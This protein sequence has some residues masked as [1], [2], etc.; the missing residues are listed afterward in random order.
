MATTS[1]SASSGTSQPR[2][3]GAANASRSTRQ[4]EPAKPLVKLVHANCVTINFTISPD[5]LKSSIPH[6][7]TLD[8]YKGDTFVSLV[9]MQIKSL[10]FCGLPI[11]PRFCELSLRC[12]V[13]ETD[14]PT[15]KGV[16]YLKSYL[17]GKF[18]AW[19]LGNLVPHNYQ[20]LAIKANHQGG[21][22]EA[23]EIDYAWKVEG[24]ENRLRVR[25]RDRIAKKET[26]TKVGFVVSH[27]S[28][29]QASQGSTIG[30]DITR[31]E[32]VLWDAAQAN[33]TCDVRRL[34]GAP[35]VKPLAARPVS[36][37]VSAGSEVTLHRPRKI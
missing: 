24:H 27:S 18:G 25:A 35:F 30:Y 37:F 16:L 6:G 14:D 15:R 2:P 34:F 5:V 28:H 20:G 33:F 8:Y 21:D 3:A 17:S 36:V 1:N 7:L 32:W 12:F 31:P 29:Y 23:P 13:S 10:P 22:L 19:A 26:S 11:I 4:A 9:C